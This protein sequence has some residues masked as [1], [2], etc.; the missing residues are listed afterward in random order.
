[1][2]VHAWCEGLASY[3][4]SSALVHQIYVIDITHDALIYRYKAVLALSIMPK[5]KLFTLSG[6][7]QQSTLSTDFE[8][9]QKLSRSELA[10]AAWTSA[11]RHQG[12][13]CVSVE[14]REDDDCGPELW[15]QNKLRSAVCRTPTKRYSVGR[16]P[17]RLARKVRALAVPCVRRDLFAPGLDRNNFSRTIEV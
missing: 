7:C 17:F 14:S 1:M 2:N 16:P 15:L 3:C 4:D 5:H 9:L 6:A 11:A 12:P 8:V 10:H 13:T